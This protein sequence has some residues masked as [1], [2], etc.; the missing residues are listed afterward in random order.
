M[1]RRSLWIGSVVVLILVLG[2]G[3]GAP[4]DTTD[5]SMVP[6]EVNDVAE[7]GEATPV[8]EAPP[9]AMLETPADQPEGEAEELLRL[10]RAEDATLFHIKIVDDKDRP[11][12]GTVVTLL[13]EDGGNI[14]TAV[15][16]EDGVVHTMLPLGKT[17]RA[18][19]LSL[20]PER[21]DIFE[22]PNSRLPIRG[23][24][25]TRF[26]QNIHPNSRL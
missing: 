20:D 6:P 11:V 26:P 24:D 19:F 7:G 23:S 14:L 18:R 2:C 4:D 8:E 16:P 21:G 5:A 12:A 15:S 3:A 1:C 13:D 10:E 22:T 9:D 17:Y 25:S